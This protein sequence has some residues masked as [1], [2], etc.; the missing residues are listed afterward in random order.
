MA[1][2]LV[3]RSKSGVVEDY[4][5]R[6]IAKGE[7]R[8]GQRL[9]QDLVAKELGVS[10]TPVREALRR[11]ETEGLVTY[12]PNKGVTVRQIDPDRV[13]DTFQLRE[14][15]ECFSTRLA[16]PR[17]TKEDLKLLSTLQEDMRTFRK[18][19][20]IASLTATND[21]WHMVIHH[22][23]GSELL[24][25]M[26]ATL[27]RASPWDTLW[28]IHERPQAALREHQLILDSLK[29]RNPLAAERAMAAHIRSGEQMLIKFL[30][31]RREPELATRG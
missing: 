20:D 25:Q 11:L 31:A 18:S 28:T 1:N 15:L 3:F 17:L 6:K 21:Q 29:A 26:I 13:H 12:L 14:L 4:L 2:D 7:I 22:A 9:Q 5:R 24:R 27:W 10:S 19:Q 8:P 30:K 16:T 23:A